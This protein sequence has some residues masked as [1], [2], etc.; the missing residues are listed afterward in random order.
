MDQS[1]EIVKDLVIFLII[2]MFGIAGSVYM[3]WKDHWQLLTGNVWPC[4]FF[5]LGYVVLAYKRF[6][7]Y[8]SWKKMY[9]RLLVFLR[10]H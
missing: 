8:S 6:S 3:I 9:Y 7:E 4:Y 5:I 2:I 1:I 10:S